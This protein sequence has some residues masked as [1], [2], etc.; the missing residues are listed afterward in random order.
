MWWRIYYE[1]GKVFTSD[2][3]EPFDAPR[4]GVEI[5]VQEKDGSHELVFGRDHF[6]WE[7]SR[8]GWMTSDWFG[9]IDHLMRSKRQCLLFGRQLNDDDWRALHKRVRDEMGERN[10][11]YAREYTRE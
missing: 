2:D 1:D 10:H 7:P 8:G 3:G 5:V 4:V 9:A 11:C 6:Y